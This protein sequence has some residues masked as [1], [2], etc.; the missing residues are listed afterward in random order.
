M[1]KYNEEEDKWNVQSFSFQEKSLSLPSMKLGQ[2]GG[3]F[4]RTNN[5]GNKQII[6]Q[7]YGDED[8]NNSNEDNDNDDNYEENIHKDFED[9]N[10]K[11]EYDMNKNKSRSKY[12]LQEDGGSSN[13]L[14]NLNDFDD[15]VNSRINFRVSKEKLYFDEKRQAK[16]QAP[17]E[18][19]LGPKKNFSNTA[20][21][22]EMNNV[23]KILMSKKEREKFEQLSN[24][25]NKEYL[26]PLHESP[27]KHRKIILNPLGS[28]IGNNY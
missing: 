21:A 3:R 9:L 18:R 13:I 17:G 1:S 5:T 11:R 12:R 14:I 22:L 8:N 26:N 16:S 6:F 2:L 10:R 25:M 7:N 27:N 4:G 23:N 15:N 20:N 28:N 19:N 24:R